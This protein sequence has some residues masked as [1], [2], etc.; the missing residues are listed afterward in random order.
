MNKV[1]NENR[2]CQTLWQHPNL[3]RVDLSKKL[4][5]DKS[6]ISIEVN[7]LIKKG[8]VIEMEEDSISPIGGRRPIPLMVN[9]NYGIIIGI[10]IQCGHYT[11]VAVN[12][13]GDFLEEKEEFLSITKDNLAL[14]IQLIYWEF[15]NRLSKHTGVLL[16]VGIGVGGIVN[17]KDGTILYSVPLKITESFNF[18]KNISEKLDTPFILENNAN[19]CAWG[20]LAFHKNNELNNILFVLVE[21]K[22]AIVPHDEYGG[23]GIGFGIVLNGKVHYGS[24]SSAGEFRSILCTENNGLQVSLSN[25]ELSQI[26]TD[27]SVLDRFASELS[28]NIAM[29]VNTLDLS[30]VFIGGDIEKCDFDFCQILDDKIQ[31]YWMYPTKKKVGIHYSSLGAKAVAFGAAGMFTHR[32]FSTDTFPSDM[33]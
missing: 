23:V 11:A 25:E 32:L 30:Q 6:T 21:F 31:K 1:K 9:K 3:S 22:Q 15:R 10:A 18:V 28:S 26:L 5:L 27:Q 16:G 20:E 14:S 17:Q 19:C 4:K 7:R 8:I 2:I 29:L 12:L 33:S 24:S 13:A